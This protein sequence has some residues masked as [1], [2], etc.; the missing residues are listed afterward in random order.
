MDEDAVELPDKCMDHH[1]F[2]DRRDPALLQGVGDDSMDDE[3]LET[4]LLPV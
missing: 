1:E 3:V 2:Q 4:H